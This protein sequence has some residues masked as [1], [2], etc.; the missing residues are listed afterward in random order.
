MANRNKSSRSRA[1]FLAGGYAAIVMAFLVVGV[2]P[3]VRGAKAAREDIDRCHAD[4][5]SRQIKTQQLQ[6]VK[7]QVE[8]IKL[9]TRDF[10]R[11]VPP[12]QDLGTFLQQLNEQLAAAG[13]RDMSYHNLPAS[14]TPLGRSEKLPIEVRGRGTFAQF[15]DFLKRLEKLPRLSSVGHL[16]VDAD[17]DMNGSVEV[18]LML[19]IYNAKPATTP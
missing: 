9:E 8:L 2:I 16:S 12:N 11:L 17:T 4:I 18:Q 5:G 1:L 6:S 7:Q 15:Q 10:D 19:Y 14:P 13:M 3:C